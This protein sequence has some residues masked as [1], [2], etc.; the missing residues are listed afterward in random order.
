MNKVERSVVQL[1]DEN[2]SHTLKE[3]SSVHVDCRSDGQDEAADVL[4]YT[5]IFLHTLHHQ[6]QCGR[7]EKEVKR[8]CECMAVKGVGMYVCRERKVCVC[9]GLVG[10]GIKL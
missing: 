3:S 1:C 9:L 10:L 7:A 8:G 5:V 6:G 2:S 4:G